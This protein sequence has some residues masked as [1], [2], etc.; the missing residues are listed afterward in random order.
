V[1]D[2]P[3]PLIEPI[4]V[5]ITI[6][7]RHSAK[8]RRK[9]KMMPS[10][11][12]EAA[13]YWIDHQEPPNDY[14][15]AVT[16]NHKNGTLTGYD[17]PYHDRLARTLRSFLGLRSIYQAVVIDAAERGIYWRGEDMDIFPK[18][19]I[20]SDEMAKDP[21]GYKKK[22]SHLIQGLGWD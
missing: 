7:K 2:T 18:I 21:D 4:G 19:I 17:T 16:E 12:R 13:Q 3:S 22:H 1:N 6:L 15:E 11:V 8:N 9:P 5:L 14:K 20:E 10:T